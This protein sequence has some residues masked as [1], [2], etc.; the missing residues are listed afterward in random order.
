QTGGSSCTGA[1]CLECSGDF[2]NKT[3]GNY[4]NITSTNLTRG[5]FTADN[6]INGQEELYFCLK[7]AGNDLTSQ[8]YSTL[9]QG[10]WTIKI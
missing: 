4:A 6:R 5:N 2:M 7:I 8:S 1:S 9:N 3:T 10:V